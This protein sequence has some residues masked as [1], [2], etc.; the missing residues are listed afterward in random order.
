MG[1]CWALM[2]L[3]VVLGGGSL[4][5]MMLLTAIMFAE[6]AMGWDD[7][8][9]KVVGLTGV[10]LGRNEFDDAGGE[11]RLA[12]L[13]P[14]L[15]QI[16]GRT[17]ALLLVLLLLSL[18]GCGS[19]RSPAKSRSSAELVPIGAGLNGPAGLRASIYARGPRT[20][21]AF[22]F[23]QH[24]R[25]WLTAA[26]LETHTE[27]GVYVISR[28][29]APTHKVVS[30]LDD[31]LG[32]DWYKG[33]LYVASVG[34]VD[35]YWGF[36]GSRF[37]EHQTIIRGPM[38]E[39]ENN[40]LVMAPD[41]R[42]V[43]G[44]SATCDH[45]VPTSRWDGA[46]VSFRPNGGDLRVYASRIR[47]PFGLAYLP[48]SGELFVTMNQQDNLGAETPGDSLA[49]VEEGQNWRFPECHGQGGPDCAG[50]P[51]PVAVLDK[52]GAVGGVA[53]ANGQLGP[54]IGTAAIV[55]E[56]NV[57]KVQ[58]VAITK[59]GNTYRGTVSSFLTG[60][61]HPLAVTF[62]SDHSLLVGDWATGAIYEVVSRSP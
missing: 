45:C 40:L 20:L 15:A 41:G 28:P 57:A 50:V 6:R 53:F 2:A 23:D 30:G 31:P 51:E 48:G 1:C 24:G 55:A 5:L 46:I 34:R 3:M 58:Q 33:K 49:A 44:V 25:L 10:A 32:L 17:K 36:N 26:G 62:A 56:W 60:I 54:S 8:F 19:T 9:V 18:A 42:F 12:V 35:A 27:D 52:H 37:T 14:R 43:M 59:S 39:G 16:T 47:A 29:G 7:R 61:E 11:P 38:A 22:A 13:V 4:Y 21:A